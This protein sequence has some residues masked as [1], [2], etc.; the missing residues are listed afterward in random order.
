MNF[1]KRHCYLIAL[2]V[3]LALA[4]VFFYAGASKL[5]S[6]QEMAVSISAYELLPDSWVWPLALSVPLIECNL[7][8]MLLTGIRLRVSALGVTVLSFIFTFVIAQAGL[9][10]LD[11]DCSCFG[12]DSSTSLEVA[13]VRDFILLIGSLWLLLYAW[14]SS[15]SA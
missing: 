8:L 12:A 1:L 10:G 11:V 13:L 6:P 2:I 7:G 9:R 15:S 3:R 14:R 4:G 5:G